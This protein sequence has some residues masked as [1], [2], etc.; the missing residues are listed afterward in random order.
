MGGDFNCH[1]SEWDDN[2]AHHRTTPILLL[3]MAANLGIE[4]APPC[5]PGPTFVSRADPNIRSVI[6][7]VFVSPS[8]VIAAAPYRREDLQGQ[9]DHIPLSTHIPLGFTSRPLKG[10]TLKPMS[11]EERLHQ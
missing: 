3:D 2:V 8:N 7:L 9:S 4:Y 11:D 10:R 6:D 5:N 1:S